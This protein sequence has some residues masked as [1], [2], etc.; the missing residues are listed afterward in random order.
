[1]D[2]ITD[3]YYR[4]CIEELDCGITLQHSIVGHR[5][6]KTA[7][8]QQFDSVISSQS[9]HPNPTIATHGFGYKANGLE[10]SKGGRQAVYL[11]AR[12]AHMH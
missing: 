8:S 12:E 1:M 7:I 6:T 2:Y 11:K 4:N 3:S 9:M 5:T 10:L